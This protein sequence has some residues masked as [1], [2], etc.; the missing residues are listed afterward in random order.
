M[1]HNEIITA[2]KE[3]NFEKVKYLIQNG[4]N[5]NATDLSG[6]TA[7]MHAASI[8]GEQGC[9]FVSFLLNSGADVFAK[10]KQGRTAYD[11][12]KEP[13]EP[14]EEHENAY[15][16]WI[17]CAEHQTMKNIG[18]HI[19]KL[20]LDAINTGDY[21][22]LEKYLSKGMNPEIM[23]YKMRTLLM[24]AVNAEKNSYELTKTLLEYGANVLAEDYEGKTVLQ[25]IQV[26][27]EPNSENI[28]A[29]NKWC[30]SNQVRIKNLIL[31]KIKEIK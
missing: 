2:I 28:T 18:Y 8:G 23:D 11:Y 31:N 16:A 14:P 17:Y 4:A 13:P 20:A 10:D 24:L 12:I 21:K 29:Y 15:E 19:E 7:L 3:L 25:H 5:I 9:D 30:N 22:N 27:R 26:R 1:K 6:V